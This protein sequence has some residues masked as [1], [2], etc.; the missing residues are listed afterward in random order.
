VQKMGMMLPTSSSKAALLQGY[1]N[2][3]QKRRDI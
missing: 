1:S 3:E 2:P